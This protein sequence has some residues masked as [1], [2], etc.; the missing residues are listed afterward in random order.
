MTEWAWADRD[1]VVK[2]FLT[3]IRFAASV[4][5][6]APSCSGAIAGSLK[7]RV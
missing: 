3:R 1:D 2:L 5:L 4:G 7:S 6:S